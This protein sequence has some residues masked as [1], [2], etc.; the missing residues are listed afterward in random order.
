[1][2]RGGSR[3][4]EEEVEWFCESSSRTQLFCFYKLD[5]VQKSHLNIS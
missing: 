1:M 3:E 5:T 4:E 2:K